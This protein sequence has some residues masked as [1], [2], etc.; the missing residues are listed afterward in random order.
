MPDFDAVAFGERLHDELER[1][2]WN[3]KTLQRHLRGRTGGAKGT[4]YGQV[5]SYVNGKAPIEPRRNVLEALAVLL[6]VRMEW[7]AFAEEPRTEQEG[8]AAEVRGWSKADMRAAQERRD[9]LLG[10]LAEGFMHGG[11][12]P[13]RKAKQ[14][15]PL[16]E[17]AIDNLVHAYVHAMALATPLP[18]HDSEEEYELAREVGRSAAAPLRAMGADPWAIDVVDLNDYVASIVPAFVLAYR[19]WKP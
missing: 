7:L 5:W 2:A 19:V 17:S 11:S 16:S 3:V 1:R 10:A 12:R 8:R 4:S 18:A 9:K 14:A 13:R 15:A 6:E